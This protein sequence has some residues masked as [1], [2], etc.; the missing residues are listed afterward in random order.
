MKVIYGISSGSN[1]NYR[2]R[3]VSILDTF[4]ID[5]FQIIL[6]NAKTNKAQAIGILPPFSPNFYKALNGIDD[7]SYFYKYYEINVCKLLIFNVFKYYNFI[8]ILVYNRLKKF[9]A[10][11]IDNMPK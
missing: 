7:R 5:T 3:A 11:F 6:K 1:D 9:T 10:N 4:S 2:F 8:N